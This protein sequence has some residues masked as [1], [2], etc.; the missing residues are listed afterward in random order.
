M[1]AA[2]A[3]S[4]IG[5][6]RRGLGDKGW[7]APVLDGLGPGATVPPDGAVFDPPHHDTGGTLV[8]RNDSS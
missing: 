8:A 3:L 2:P 5:T 1:P 4:A 6:G 7:T